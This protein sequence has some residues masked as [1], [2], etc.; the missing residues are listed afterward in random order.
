MIC[1]NLMVYCQAVNQKIFV[2]KNTLYT[3][4]IKKL[5][6]KKF[7]DAISILEKIKN[8]IDNVDKD[9]IF[10]HLIY[11]YYK[12]L[13]LYMAQ[14][15]AQEFIMLYPNHK[16]KDYV[17]YLQS[18]ISWAMDQNRFFNILP[19]KYHTSNPIHAIHALSQLKELIYYYP[20][21][22]YIVNAKKQIICIQHRLSEYDFQ[23]LQFYFSLKEHV[24]VIN[25][26]IEIIQ[27][28]PDTPVAKKT[29]LYMQKSYTA[30]NIFDAAKKIAK[31][32]LLNN[33]SL[34]K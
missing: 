16:N 18:L 17:I 20:N 9:K 8:N 1:F 21:S 25:R 4:S 19:I 34:E 29:L 5:K 24:A 12:N 30:L 33:V 26:G 14:K 31:I 10:I 3:Y 23:I 2:I 13:N 28:Y 32:L 11:A 22:A 7:D 27:K 6:E 15:T